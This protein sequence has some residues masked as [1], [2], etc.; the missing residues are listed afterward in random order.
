MNLVEAEIEIPGLPHNHRLRALAFGV[1]LPSNQNEPEGR[2]DGGDSRE[3]D[4][5]SQD[6]LWL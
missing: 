6:G 4:H 1:G 5:A 3:A 2:F